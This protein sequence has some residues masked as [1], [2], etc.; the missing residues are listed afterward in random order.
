VI[1][2]ETEA[3]TQKSL[4]SLKQ[5]PELAKALEEIFN[6][7]GAD[8]TPGTQIVQRV[9]GNYN[10]TIGQNYGTAINTVRGDVHF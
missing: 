3:A 10:Q 2:N 6:E 5:E 8:G 9:I 7:N 4:K 1:D